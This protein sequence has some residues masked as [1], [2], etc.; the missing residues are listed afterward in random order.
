M[1]SEIMSAAEAAERLGVCRRR[2]YQLIHTRLLPGVKRGRRIL[3][4]RQ[5]FDA[6]IQQINHAAF[7]NVHLAESDVRPAQSETLPHTQDAFTDGAPRPASTLFGGQ[8]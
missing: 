6:Y 3:I 7:G 5:A 8:A 2:V 1:K 4:P